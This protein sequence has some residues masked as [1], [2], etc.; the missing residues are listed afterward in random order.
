MLMATEKP[1]TQTL[2]VTQKAIADTSIPFR[3]TV[4]SSHGQIRYTA[5]APDLRTAAVHLVDLFKLQH[6]TGRIYDMTAAFQNI[7]NVW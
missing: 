3:I 5:Y 2:N 6:P 7:P 1:A 4:H